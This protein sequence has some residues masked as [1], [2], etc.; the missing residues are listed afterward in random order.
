MLDENAFRK[1]SE[2]A[3]EAL[4]KSLLT[5]EEDGDFEVEEQNGVLNIL[6]E[7]S[8]ARFVITPNTPIRQIWIS[9]LTTSFKLDWSEEAAA[10]VLP[11]DGT[12]LKPLVARLINQQLGHDAVTL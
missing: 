11:K 4:K 10:F 12:P 9:A 5:A 1:H 2:A 8:G 3:L 6:F 7:D